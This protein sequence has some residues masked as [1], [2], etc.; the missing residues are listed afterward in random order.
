MNLC[1]RKALDYY[2]DLAQQAVEA[3]ACRSVRKQLFLKKKKSPTSMF[4]DETP[5][6]ESRRVKHSNSPSRVPFRT[7]MLAEPELS[8]STV[9]SL[10][11][12]FFTQYCHH[13]YCMV[14]GIHRGG[15]VGGEAYIA[16]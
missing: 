7:Y 10:C 8:A 11:N 15:G 6:N 2:R 13:Q 14:Y 16:Q 1:F 5:Q 9:Y 3:S 12:S 4:Y